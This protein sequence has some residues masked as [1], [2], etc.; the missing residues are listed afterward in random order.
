MLTKNAGGGKR[1]LNTAIFKTMKV[2]SK[3]ML[4]KSICKLQESMRMQTKGKVIMLF[5]RWKYIS[6]RGEVLLS[7]FEKWSGLVYKKHV[8]KMSETF[9]LEWKIDNFSVHGE[10]GVQRR[11]KKNIQALTKIELF[12]YQL[13]YTKIEY[14]KKFSA[15]GADWPIKYFWKK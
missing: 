2:S 12:T 6:K 14:Y 5:S 1:A 7:C 11:Y 8:N 10:P 9:F 4:C 13:K 15:H 3:L